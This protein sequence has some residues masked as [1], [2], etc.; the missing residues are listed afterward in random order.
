MAC[1]A[2]IDL[3]VHPVG[4]HRGDEGMRSARFRRGRL[5]VATAARPPRRSGSLA[6][7]QVSPVATPR[8]PGVRDSRDHM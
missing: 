2:G 7:A 5:R 1:P 3:L 8:F 6:L 4:Q